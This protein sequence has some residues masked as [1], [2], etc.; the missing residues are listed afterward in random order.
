MGRQKR[1]E[2]L[3]AAAQGLAGVSLVGSLQGVSQGSST[4]ASTAES[5]QGD[6][7]YRTLGKTGEKVSLIC[8][9]GAHIGYA[10][11]EDR[12]A[13]RIMHA[14]IDAGVNFFDN[15]WDYNSGGSE[16]RMGRALAMDGKRGKVFLMTKFCCHRQGWSKRVALDML[17]ESL[18][19][20]R[21]DYLDLWQLHEVSA[22]DHAFNAYLDDGALDAMR[23]A[24]EAGKVRYVGF[25]GHT[26]P[27]VHLKMLEGGFPF[28]TVQLPL[29]V[30]DAH[31]LS[32]QKDVLPE[33]VSRH[34]GVIAMKPLGGGSQ[35][36]AIPSTDAVTAVECLHYVMN[37]PVST[38]CTGIISMETL[39]Q[40]VEAVRTFRPLAQE[41][42][43]S[44]L[45][46]T[47]TLA[48]GGTHESYKRVL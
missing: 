32:F 26:N 34:I 15:S 5:S 47:R 38:V 31:F 24:K 11:V 3:K 19:R 30:L 2:F 12:Q 29:N 18:R 41:E 33:L 1:R 43:A 23:E 8:L 9:G 40:A 13:L 6:M 10:H 17:E 45:A 37:L 22:P 46:R 39:E 25:T 36:G 35:Q 28:D 14:A 21:T 44:L 27:F 4:T 20:L 48:D 16:E 42:V 7:P